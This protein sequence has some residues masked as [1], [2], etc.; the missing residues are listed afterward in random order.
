MSVNVGT[1]D[2]VIVGSGIAGLTAAFD[3]LRN[4]PLCKLVVLEA[5]S[6][7]SQQ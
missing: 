2:I 3:L 7:Y 6:K 5:K 1:L 4:N